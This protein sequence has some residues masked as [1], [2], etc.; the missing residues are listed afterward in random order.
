[1]SKKSSSVDEDG[2][3]YRKSRHCTCCTSPTTSQD[4][5]DAGNE[6]ACDLDA[7]EF[8]SWMVKNF[9]TGELEHEQDSSVAVLVTKKS[10]I[11]SP[12]AKSSFPCVASIDPTSSTATTTSSTSSSSRYYDSFR[13]KRK[14]QE[15]RA[16]QKLIM[17]A[18]LKEKRDKD[19]SFSDKLMK[20]ENFPQS[21]MSQHFLPRSKTLKPIINPYVIKAV[22]KRTNQGS[23]NEGKNNPFQ[24]DDD[25]E[26]SETQTRWRKRDFKEDVEAHEEK[27]LLDKNVKPLK[28]KTNRPV[29][30]TFAK[31]TDEEKNSY[32]SMCENTK[33]DCHDVVMG[34]FC[35]DQF[36]RYYNEE[37]SMADL[38]TAKKI[39]ISSYHNYREIM[40]Y[41]V[42]KRL[43]F[44][45][46]KT[47]PPGCVMMGSFGF[48]V[49]WFHLKK[50]KGFIDK[51]LKKYKPY[52]YDHKEFRRL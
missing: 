33:S 24:S 9:Q 50:N 30:K 21:T 18:I 22:T 11:T 43:E 45:M 8:E 37:K 29:Y 2:R 51:K 27:F 26:L 28:K 14:F 4:S 7:G 17:D 20:A 25:L 16:E 23:L 1:M 46:N 5:E 40:T 42:T 39:F 19:E 12:T 35:R 32:C 10:N 44:P 6:D 34:P 49:E 47:Y 3:R 38:L 13:K 31:L 36:V 41:N 48:S 15:L 52:V